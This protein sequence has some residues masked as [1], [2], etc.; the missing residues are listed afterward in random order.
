MQRQWRTGGPNLLPR[1]TFPFTPQ[2][3]PRSSRRFMKSQG[4]IGVILII[5]AVC[6][7][8]FGGFSFT[9]QAQLAKIGP[10]QINGEKT[11]SVNI[12]SIIGWVCMAGGVFLVAT[13]FR[14]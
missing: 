10:V 4:V 7:L 14:K 9:H 13:G 11:D 2:S 8:Y 3:F 6:I 5:V 1:N 12:P